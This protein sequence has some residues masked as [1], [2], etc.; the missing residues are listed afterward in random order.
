M[1][2]RRFTRRDLRYGS[3]PQ[4][5]ISVLCPHLKDLRGALEDLP[6]WRVSSVVVSST[7]NSMSH[8][9]RQDKLNTILKGGLTAAE[10]SAVGAIAALTPPKPP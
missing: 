1:L 4:K 7:F 6:S 5:I 10:L 2:P 8:Q 9:S 3:A